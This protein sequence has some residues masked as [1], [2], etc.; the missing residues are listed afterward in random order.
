[1][2]GH[3]PVEPGGSGRPGDDYET[4]HRGLIES[5]DTLL[6]RGLGACRTRLGTLPS[7]HRPRGVVGHVEIAERKSQEPAPSG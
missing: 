2:K 1:M 7:A 6:D 4:Q 5:V 3:H